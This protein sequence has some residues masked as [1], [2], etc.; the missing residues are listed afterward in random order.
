MFTTNPCSNTF[1]VEKIKDTEKPLGTR[2][3]GTFTTIFTAFAR[4]NTSRFG[5]A[6]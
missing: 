6:F 5:K 4:K 2:N 3:K 1:V